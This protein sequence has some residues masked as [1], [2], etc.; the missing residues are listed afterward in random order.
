MKKFATTLVMGALAV[1]CAFGF[2]ACG[3]E[4]KTTV[5]EEEWKTAIATLTEGKTSFKSEWNYEYKYDDVEEDILYVFEL[6]AEN[7]G[8][9]FYYTS[10]DDGEKMEYN[11]YC[12]VDAEGN[13]YSAEFD[14]YADE[15]VKMACDE[16]EY[17][18]IKAMYVDGYAG[19]GLITSSGLENKYG[20]FEYNAK[21]KAYTGT[22]SV[23]DES[24]DVV[25]KF[26]D[27]KLVYLCAKPVEEEDEICYTFT[28]TYGI[29]VTIPK[30]VLDMPVEEE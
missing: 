4:A 9:H 23:D 10:E 3:K 29:K 13:A 18:E 30:D 28:Y 5:T 25:L 26:K 20:D 1:A 8:C 15:P 6:D 24:A 27:G 14:P 19:V 7:K 2:T 22:L 16:D 21:D 11:S 12:W 17:A